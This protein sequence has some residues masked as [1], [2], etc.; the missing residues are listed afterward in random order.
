MLVDLSLTI[1][2]GSPIFAGYPKPVIQPWTNIEVHGYNSNI[3]LLPEHTLTHVDVPYHFFKEGFDCEHMP[4]D[5]FM[6]KAIV[7]DF[8]NIGFKKAIRLEDFKA[9]VK[10]HGFKDVK[11][12]IVLFHTGFDKY[13]GNEEVYFGK[14]PYIDINLAKYLVESGV[15]AVGVDTPSVDYP[16]FNVHKILL[17]NNIPIYECLTNLGK[18]AGKIV[19]F[20]GFPLKIKFGTASPVRAVAVL[21]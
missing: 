9:K 8:S 4:L 17:S 21:T 1:K 19:T 5:K 14:Y 6:G 3:L 20:Y 10:E 18:I 11:G 2:T 13:L 15:K 7:V 12:L 16:P